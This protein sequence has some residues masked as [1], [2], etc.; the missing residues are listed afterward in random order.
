[1]LGG[2]HPGLGLFAGSVSLAGGHGT[3]IAWG[4]EATKAGIEGAEL[5]GIAFATFGLVAGGIIGGPLAER[6][7]KKYLGLTPKYF[8]YPYGASNELLIAFLKK[9]GYRGG[10]KVSPG[11]NPFYTDR[12]QVKRSVIYGN[13]DIS[14]FAENLKTFT[15]QKLQ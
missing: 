2:E 1:M 15:K 13:Y 9:K 14:R 4:Q 7:I 3:A 12:F 5:T 10:L 11:G 8:A 6:L